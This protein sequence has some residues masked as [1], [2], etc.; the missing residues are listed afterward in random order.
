MRGNFIKTVLLGSIVMSLFVS[1]ISFA[2]SVQENTDLARISNILN[3]VY[4][5]IV[6]AEQHATPNT[7][8]KFRYDWLRSDI[9]AIQAGIAQKI[10]AAKIEPRIVKPLQTQYVHQQNSHE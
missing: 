10:N 4:P 7:R 6:D 5:L 8:I 1:G 2:D 3:S 9:Q